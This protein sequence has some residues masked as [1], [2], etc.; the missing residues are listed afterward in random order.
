MLVI[1]LDQSSAHI[2]LGGKSQFEQTG[3]IAL[4]KRAVLDR[5]TFQLPLCVVF[6]AGLQAGL[7]VLLLPQHVNLTVAFS[8]FAATQSANIIALL[9]FREI[10]RVPGTRKFSVILPSFLIAYTVPTLFIL[11]FRLHYS[12]VIGLAGFLGGIL[13]VWMMHGMRRTVQRETLHIIPSAYTM[14][15]VQEVTGLDADIIDGVEGLRQLA[16]G[17]VIVDL[18][19]DISSEWEREIA[20]AVLRGIPVY[21]VKQIYESLTGRVRI[22]SLSENAFGALV[23]SKSYLLI[24]RVI[25]IVL[26]AL[27][28]LIFAV[29][30]AFIAAAIR[31][32]S[33]G[34]AIFRHTRIGYRGKSFRTLKFRTMYSDT[35]DHADIENQ[36]TVKGDLRITPV[37]RFLRS[38]RLD[39]VPQ[40]INVLRGEMSLIGPRPEALALSEWYQKHLD[41]YDYRHIVRPGIT[42]W[43]QV[44]QGHVVNLEDVSVKTQYDFYY[45]KNISGWLDFLI[46]I[47]TIGVVLKRDGAH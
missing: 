9:I 32:D 5:Y 22:D 47:R 6:V 29:P 42:G 15:L 19:E 26:S 36:M 34:P 17:A 37:G 27:G 28:L 16:G 21:H 40:L 11:F 10:R 2:P 12:L 39:E 4:G 23:P 25:D 44:N 33:P 24:K 38:I 30:M 8:T 7:A 20:R 1:T 45:I 46:M 18:R 41:F 3:G 43:A 35:S 31:L 13:F 14:L